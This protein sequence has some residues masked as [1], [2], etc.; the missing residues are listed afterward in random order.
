MSLLGSEFPLLVVSILLLLS[1]AV[2]VTGAVT[3]ALLVELVVILARLG[4][5]VDDVNND[6]G[7]VVF[8]VRGDVPVVV[9]TCVRTVVEL[10]ANPA[11]FS[12]NCQLERA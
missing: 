7:V 2:G 1:A 10:P 9:D 11:A 4:P 5:L 3:P 6:A 12:I 8:V